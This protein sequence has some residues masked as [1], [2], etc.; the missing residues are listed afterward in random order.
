MVSRHLER[1]IALLELATFGAVR[2]ANAFGAQF[3]FR[4]EKFVVQFKFDEDVDDRLTQ[5]R[6]VR[7]RAGRFW[8][9]VTDIFPYRVVKE[10]VVAKIFGFDEPEFAFFLNPLYSTQSFALDVEPFLW[11]IVFVVRFGHDW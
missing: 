1:G 6:F 7:V 8:S 10:N 5:T 9:I 2:H 11:F 3:L 4:G